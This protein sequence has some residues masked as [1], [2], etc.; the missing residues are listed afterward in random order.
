MLSYAL[1]TASSYFHLPVD[2][3]EDEDIANYYRKRITYTRSAGPS[4]GVA[5]ASSPASE[6]WTHSTASSDEIEEILATDNLYTVLGVLKSDKL[7]K[8]SLRRAYLK[9]SRACH[10]DKYPDNPRATH[11]FQKIALA[12]TVLGNPA[13]R[14][15]YERS[16]SKHD[17]FAAQ[18]TMAHETFRSIILGVLDDFLDGDL[19]MIRTLLKTINDVNPSL[20]VGE[21]GINAILNS[22]QRIRE[23][24]L[25]CRTCIYALGAEISRLSEVQ[26]SFR[27]LS[28][29]DIR[30]RTRLTMQLARI[31]LT[32]PIQLER[33]IA[34]Q[35]S[36]KDSATDEAAIL[37]RRLTLLIRGVDVL[38][39]HLENMI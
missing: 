18:T 15:S 35:N 1:S 22:V 3:Q 16:P 17:I 31:T 24:L 26:Y 20:G 36:S 11:A 37:P 29:F 14:R 34:E 33:A 9:R 25:T 30:G 12:Y 19:E 10:P 8:H 5:S 7:D 39:Q 38:L 32:L 4:Y 6:P 28:Y 2:E 27:Q 13:S 23:R 21:E